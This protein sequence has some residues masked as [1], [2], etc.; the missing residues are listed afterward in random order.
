M[1]HAGWGPT[2]RTSQVYNQLIVQIKSPTK[3][4]KRWYIWKIDCLYAACSKSNGISAGW[5]KALERPRGADAGEFPGC[6]CKLNLALARM[7]FKGEPT[8]FPAVRVR[9]WCII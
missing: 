4:Q 3:L 6:H 1:S 9:E 8:A 2:G 5:V 7:A